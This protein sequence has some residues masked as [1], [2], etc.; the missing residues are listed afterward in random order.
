MIIRIFQLRYIMLLFISM[1]VI[2]MNGIKVFDMSTSKKVDSEQCLTKDTYDSCAGTFK[3]NNINKESKQIVQRLLLVNNIRIYEKYLIISTIIIIIMSIV[4]TIFPQPWL[5][6]IIIIIRTDLLFIVYFVHQ[7][8]NYLIDMDIQTVVYI[9]IFLEIDILHTNYFAMHSYLFVLLI[10]V[11]IFCIAICLC[12]TINQLNFNVLLLQQVLFIPF[13]IAYVA[14]MAFRLIFHVL[15]I[16]MVTLFILTLMMLL[17]DNM[18]QF[19]TIF[20][21]ATVATTTV[22]TESFINLYVFLIVVLFNLII[23]ENDV[24]VY[25]YVYDIGYQCNLIF[26]NNN[27][28]V[29]NYSLLMNKIVFLQPKTVW[30]NY[31]ITQFGLQQ[32][33]IHR[34]SGYLLQ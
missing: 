8:S 21:V 1:V 17:T 15:V 34:S 27:G 26:C 32:Y 24:V 20:Y 14:N 16:I 29:W 10:L 19:D 12:E 30:F 18:H 11:L 28:Q 2:V 4:D 22:S 6:V 33:L 7:L 13:K 3:Y 31:G 9:N 5:D 23:N 25:D